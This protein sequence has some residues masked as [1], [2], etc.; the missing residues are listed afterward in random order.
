MPYIGK[1]TEICT[2][3]EMMLEYL[4]ELLDF[5]NVEIESD[6]EIH[7][8][9]ITRREKVRISR[10]IMAKFSLFHIFRLRVSPLL[11]FTFDASGFF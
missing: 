1:H 9:K 5:S 4:D 6:A 10:R 8:R 2:A 3:I 7:E 11:C